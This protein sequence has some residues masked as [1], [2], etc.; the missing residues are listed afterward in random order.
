MDVADGNVLSRRGSSTPPAT[1][2][3]LAGAHFAQIYIILLIDVFKYPAFNF[4]K[5]NTNTGYVVLFSLAEVACTLFLL[6]SD[7][8]D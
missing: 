4:L 6:N 2:G 5:R 8:N 7:M 3:K 1:A